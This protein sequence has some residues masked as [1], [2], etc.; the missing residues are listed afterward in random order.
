MILIVSMT[1]TTKTI[2]KT[3]LI[4]AIAVAFV[5]GT[6]VSSPDVFAK[7]GDKPKLDSFTLQYS[8]D[9]STVDVTIYDKASSDSKAKPMST[10]VQT[11]NNGES[12]TYVKADMDKNKG[13][14]KNDSYFRLLE[15]GTDNILAE[16]KIHV[17]C[18]KPL[19][20]GDIH[21]DGDY[22]L[23]VVGDYCDPDVQPPIE[24]PD[25]EE[26]VDDKCVPSSPEPP[27]EIFCEEVNLCLP[28]G[29]A[30]PTGPAGPQ[31]PDG[32]TGPAGPVGP[33]GAT[34]PAGPQG[35]DGPTGPAGPQG[36]D[37]AT[38]PAG[39]QGPPGELSCEVQ[40]L[41]K[42]LLEAHPD[43]EHE[44]NVDAECMIPPE[45]LD[46]QYRT[47]TQGGWGTECKGNNPG[48][49]R[50]ANFDNAFNPSL[51]VGDAGGFT[52][53]LTNSDAVEDFLPAGG[54]K[55]AF[56]QDYVDPE[57]TTAGVF[58]GQVTALSLSVGFDMCSLAGDCDTFAPD[59]ADRAPTTLADLIV[60][61][62]TSACFEM[63]VG[64]ILDEA[65]QAI[66]GQASD[67]SLSDL[68]ECVSDI[69]ENFVDGDTDNGFLAEP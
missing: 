24:C 61:D 64:E 20:D 19:K 7:G 9:T 50:D 38:G 10:F 5:V 17:S 69:N 22:S 15:A 28:E 26:L 16:I 52:L 43:L 58:A 48:C 3:I 27:E 30:G 23:I 6:A 36:P 42:W 37:G 67:P 39:P 2:P 51:I 68:N 21:T 49:Y 18:S 14:W 12:F 55:A 63:T 47:Q 66:S 25:G 57:E 56:D 31:G 13:S 54:P 65:N 32:A 44:F 11:V 45:E 62:N 59:E 35:P 34:G 53:T 41:L 1:N 33:D 46:G 8:G 4:L 40:I 29:P 60:V